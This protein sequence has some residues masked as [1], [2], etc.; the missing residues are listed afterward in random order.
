M[1][2]LVWF[3]GK[4]LRVG[5]HAALN[6]A[7][8]R[9]EVVPLF[10]LDPYFFA[11][12][13]AQQTP[14]RSQFLLESLGQLAESLHALGSRLLVASGKS[15]EVVPAMARRWRVD[16]VVA[17]RWCVPFGR[18]RDRRVSESLHVPFELFDGETLH[19][20]GTLRTRQGKPF[21]VFTAFARAFHEAPLEL[22]PAARPERLPALP[23]DI[24]SDGTALPTLQQLGL[25]H[26]PRL[27]PGGEAAA[28]A[29]LDA[30][31]R[32]PARAYDA[33]RDRLDVDAT[34]RL[35]ADLKFGT[36]SPRSVWRR[37]RRSLSRRPKARDSF[38][39]EL[40]W[41]EFA[42]ASLWDQPEL[43]EQPFRREWE[44][45][46]WRRSEA[47]WQAWVTG[48]TGY[49][50]IDAAARQLE[51]EGFVPNRA[52]MLAASFLTKHLL[53]DYRRGEAHYLRLLTDGDW[54]QN[55]LNWQWCAGCGCDAQPYFRV[56][57]PILQAQRFDPE[58]LYVSRW[59][60]ELA[61]LPARYLH[62]P[63]L[64]PPATLAQAGVQLGRDYPLPIIEHG[65]AR[66][67]FLA[68]A[69]GHLR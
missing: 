48:H 25:S 63:W 60:P 54:A 41:R 51:C 13:R 44:D 46:P 62:A 5:D 64:A 23:P 1:R 42:H 58:G 2:T 37:A 14:H 36:L 34:S 40:L 69:R 22:E 47:D 17:Q 8:R 45:F 31:L 35:S 27:L 56:F 7:V 9:G 12:E 49:P 65:L 20:P 3:R 43:L 55:N 33:E 15:H 50:V 68:L 59:L 29:R 38:L 39:K 61:R 18:E 28:E 57:N 30:F 53:L 32:G 67:R 16:R 19:R 24:V 52:R 21:A 6:D 4:D 11:P 66:Q 10:V 26:N